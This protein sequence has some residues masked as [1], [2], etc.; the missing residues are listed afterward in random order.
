M[1]MLLLLFFIVFVLFLFCSETTC[2]IVFCVNNKD[3][4]VLLPLFLCC[5]LS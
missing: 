5:L 2:F 4:N 3:V 1:S